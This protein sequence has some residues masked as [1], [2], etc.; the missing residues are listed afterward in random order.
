MSVYSQSPVV[1][2]GVSGV[3]ATRGSH[4][5]EIG[6]RVNFGGNEYVYVYNAGNSQISPGY[7]AVPAS[8]CTSPYSCTVSSTAGQNLAVGLCK[9]ATLT[10]GTYGYLLYRGVGKATASAT[11]AAGDNAC[12]GVDGALASA[13]TYPGIAKFI[14]ATVTGASGG[15]VFS[16][17]F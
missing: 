11:V 4:D 15:V 9:N 12:L 16:A 2:G 17:S 7:A 6:S 13:V 1:F 3:T 14:S 8:G 10:T 5:P